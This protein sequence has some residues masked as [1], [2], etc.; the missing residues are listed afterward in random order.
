M[1][2]LQQKVAAKE[3]LIEIPFHAASRFIPNSIF[4]Q[5]NQDNQAHITEAQVCC[6][7]FF[8]TT[9]MLL[10]HLAKSPDSKTDVFCLL[11]KLLFDLLIRTSQNNEVASLT[12]LLLDLV[13][14][15]PQLLQKLI[16]ERILLVQKA[17][18]SV[19]DKPFFE[20]LIF[21]K[22]QATREMC[23]QILTKVVATLF[24]NLEYHNITKLS[25]LQIASYQEDLKEIVD[26][27]VGV[28]PGKLQN[29]WPKL[30]AFFNFFYNTLKDLNWGK[31]ITFKKAN[32]LQKLVDLIC[33]MKEPLSSGYNY[34]LPPIEFA[35]QTI[36]VLARAQPLLI[37]LYKMPLS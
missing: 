26:A 12:A 8:K 11:D 2:Q 34:G 24:Q 31:L 10:R 33:K 21:H 6:N 4:K 22:E 16:R 32:L 27:A 3:P 18:D 5:V 29:A 30:G 35:I 15:S 1:A 13:S 37:W 28:I 17:S 7:P 14:E 23:E 36:S 20:M 25:E 19:C 9:G